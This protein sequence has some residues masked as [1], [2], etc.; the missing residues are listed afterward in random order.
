[1]LGSIKSVPGSH[2][3]PGMPPES[4]VQAWVLI[5][6][7]YGAY[8]E[9]Y[10]RYRSEGVKAGMKVTDDVR[11]EAT[12]LVADISTQEEKLRGIYEFCRT[13]IRRF[14]DD[15]TEDVAQR[16]ADLAKE[17]KTPSDT[18]KRKAGTGRDIDFLFASLASAVGFD[19]RY[20]ELSDRGRFFFDERY[21][22]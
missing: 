11:N 21:P 12:R 5:Y 3:E 9:D 6:Y 8:W 10:A 22:T 20:A 7:D 19:V 1:I 14:D 15:A 2:T 4:V 17:N 18:L 13:E 16:A